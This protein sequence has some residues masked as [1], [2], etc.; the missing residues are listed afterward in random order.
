MNYFARRQDFSKINLI[1]SAAFGDGSGTL[2]VA[3]REAKEVANLI[4]GKYYPKSKSNK[5]NF[6]KAVRDLELVHFAGHSCFCP[7]KPMQSFLVLKDG[8]LTAQEIL[9]QMS[10]EKAKCKLLVLSSCCSGKS[11]VD[12]GDEIFGLVRAFLMVGVKRLAV[13]LNAV[14]DDASR[15]FYLRFYE[16]IKKKMRPDQSLTSIYLKHAKRATP[17]YDLPNVALF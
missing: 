8:R 3:D 9:A 10:G 11:Q 2:V 14:S 17:L 16:N 4:G 12:R 15:E 5:K 13:N 7:E 1:N 6:L